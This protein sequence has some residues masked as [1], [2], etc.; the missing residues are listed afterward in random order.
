MFIIKQLG[1]FDRCT[2]ICGANERPSAGVIFK[3]MTQDKRLTA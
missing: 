3:Y 2:V 1:E